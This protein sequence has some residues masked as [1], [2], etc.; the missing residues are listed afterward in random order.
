MGAGLLNGLLIGS[1]VA[2]IS[3]IWNQSALL[4]LVVGLSMVGVHIV[5]GFAGAFVPLLL[6]H[7][8]KDPAAMSTIFITTATDVSGL[9][10]LLGLGTL[11]LI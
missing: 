6:K 5:A 2:I 9:F 8:G 3:I 7:F 4:G 11:I 10:I 1:I